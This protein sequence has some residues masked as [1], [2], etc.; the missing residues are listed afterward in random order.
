MV[1][2]VHSPE[3]GSNSLIQEPGPL[4]VPVQCVATDAKLSCQHRLWFASLCSLC[5][6]CY[7]VVAQGLR[8]PLYRPL[9]FLP[10]RHLPFDVRESMSAQIQ[11]RLPSLCANL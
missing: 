11:Q 9:D 1:I 6:L 10:E 2:A 5:Q 7:L 3:P 8:A 4:K